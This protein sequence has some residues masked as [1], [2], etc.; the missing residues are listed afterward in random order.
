MKRVLFFIALLIGYQM[1]MAQNLVKIND[2]SYI[3]SKN[4]FI[5]SIDNQDKELN[6]VQSLNE[7]TFVLF[8]DTKKNIKSQKFDS[9]NIY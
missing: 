3:L 4:L 7:K 8:V 6:I 5:K 1:V 9:R 2:F